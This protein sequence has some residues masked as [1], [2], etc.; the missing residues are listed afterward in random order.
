[1][2]YCI[3]TYLLL[4]RWQYYQSHI[5]YH[6]L[7]A[8]YY[9]LTIYV[10][11]SHPYF[12]RTHLLVEGDNCT[13]F[14]LLTTYVVVL[15][16][17]IRVPDCIRIHLSWLHTYQWLRYWSRILTYLLVE[18]DICT[19]FTLLN[20]IRISHSWLHTCSWLHTYSS[21]LTTYVLV[22]HSY[23]PACWRWQFYPP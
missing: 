9:L 4:E 10:L 6:V 23:V 3:L 5:T 11:V 12:L 20:Y 18:G 7:L 17:C 2:T 1:M 19:C 22:S 16:G 8:A 14:T 15:T 13:S 21:F